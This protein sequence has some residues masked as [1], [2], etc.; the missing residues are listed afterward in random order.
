M[1]NRILL[2]ALIGIFA[3]GCGAQTS[4]ETLVADRPI[5][6]RDNQEQVA[7]TGEDES[8]DED[9]KL[10]TEVESDIYLSDYKFEDI[11]SFTTYDLDGN[12]VTE[13][14]FSNADYTMVNIWGTF[15]GPCIGE[16]PELA[17]ISDEL[18]DNMQI[19]GIVCDVTK[20]DQRS[21]SDAQDI[22]STTGV[23]YTN[24][25]YTSDFDQYFTDFQ[26]VP[27]TFFV[28]S[29]GRLVNEIIEGADPNA[30]RAVI[31]KLGKL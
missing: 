21:L 14:I 18:P 16:M 22:L 29:E 9:D 15:C 27:T 30:Y 2:L 24:I 7:S 3:T 23:S 13:D 25:M 12:E 11:G 20:D 4:T 6:H 8:E 31:N 10:E 17:K 28:D 5:Y 1:K 19:I 26:Y